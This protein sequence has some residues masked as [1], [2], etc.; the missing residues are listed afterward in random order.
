MQ[1]SKARADRRGSVAAQGPE[2]LEGRRLM[3]A[4]VAQVNVLETTTNG[5]PTLVVRGT[6][7]ADAISV[8]DN[9]TG[10]AG[11]I[12]VS[13]GNGQTYTSTTAVTA[14]EIL[15]QGGNDQVS[16]TL[17][18]NLAVARSVLV[19]LGAGNDHFTANIA[20]DISNAG[21]GLDLEAFGDA[22]N[23][24]MAVNQ[25]G[26]VAAGTFV[27]YLEGDAG[28]DTLSYAGTA[29]IASGAA[30][31]PEFSGGAGND[32]IVSTE[33]GQIVG[34]YLYNLSADG[35]AGNDSITDT[36]NVGAGSTGL[37][38][39]DATR[40]AVIE[41]GTGND[42]LRFVIHV[43]PAATAT[44]VFAETDGGPGK[45][46]AQQTTN[47]LSDKSNEKATAVS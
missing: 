13:Y 45:D 21:G 34:N 29:N 31:N 40:P 16:Y 9:G 15:G 42:A 1:A 27:P 28:N 14:V 17:A 33:S 37:I 23:D 4:A 43:D 47:V 3:A 20:G 8:V 10:A 36:I 39:T 32:T 44:Q 30:L 41:G 19:D 35:G 5:A 26:S 18:G 2:A 24:V 12:T 38:G 11:N 6:N 7:R 25:T 22:G 46:T